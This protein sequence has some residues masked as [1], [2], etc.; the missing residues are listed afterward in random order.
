[1]LLPIEERG[2]AQRAAGAFPTTH[3]W[4]FLPAARLVPVRAAATATGDEL[5]AD[6][7]ELVTAI[8]FGERSLVGYHLFVRDTTRWPNENS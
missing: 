1:M 7:V 8:N 3:G 5:L 2:D 4:C 6:G